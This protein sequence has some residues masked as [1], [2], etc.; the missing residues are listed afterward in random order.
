MYADT[1]DGVISQYVSDCLYR[2]VNHVMATTLRTLDKSYFYCKKLQWIIDLA[3]IP[4][5]PIVL[6]IMIRF[7]ADHFDKL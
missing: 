1:L 7:Y 6:E 5:L 2:D 3:K 4:Y